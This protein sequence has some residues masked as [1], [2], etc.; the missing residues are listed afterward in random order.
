MSEKF[1][2]ENVVHGVSEYIE[3]LFDNIPDEFKAD[4]ASIIAFEA[5][6]WGSRNLVEA[7][8][9]LEVTKMEYVQTFSEVTSQETSNN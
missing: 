5:I 8:G 3:N 1:N 4:L 2:P 7:I 9:I 6:N